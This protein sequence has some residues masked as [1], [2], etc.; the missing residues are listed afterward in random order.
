MSDQ[1]IFN[2]IANTAMDISALVNSMPAPALGFKKM[3]IPVSPRLCVTTRKDYRRALFQAA[4]IGD[5]N[6]LDVLVGQVEASEEL[7]DEEACDNALWVAVAENHSS[8]AMALLKSPNIRHKITMPG[9]K[10]AMR[11]SLEQQ[12]KTLI[13]ALLNFVASAKS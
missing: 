11:M 9:V 10:E 1:Q 8:F 6:T 12:D 4:L 2:Q 13:N 3:S 7:I 5:V